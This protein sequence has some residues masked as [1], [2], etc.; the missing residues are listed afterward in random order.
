VFDA[1]SSKAADVIRR[2]L[3]GK[4]ERSEKMKVNKKTVGL[5]V[6]AVAAAVVFAGCASKKADAVAK[7]VAPTQ[8]VEVLDD[9]GAAFGIPT[10]EWVAA[11]IMGGNTAVEKL[12]SYKGKYAFIVESADANKDYAIAWVQNASGPQ[13]I[14]AKVSTTVASSASNALSGE[15]DRGVES[16]LKAATEQL[17]NASFNGATRDADWWQQVHNLTTDATEFRAYGLW[18]IDQK[19]LDTQVAASLQRIVDQNT[20]MSAAEKAIY[21]DLIAQ[22]RSIGGYGSLQ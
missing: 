2:E 19:I 18:T 20:A 1:S 6:L 22:V 12:S 10:P 9:K 14:A 4:D 17:S 15:H 13:Q 11:Y 21:N 3:Y 16:N 8:K 7:S 5:L